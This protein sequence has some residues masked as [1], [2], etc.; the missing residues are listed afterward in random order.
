MIQAPIN[1]PPQAYLDILLPLIDRARGFLEAGEALAPMAFVGALEDRHFVPVLMNNG[2]TEAK[3]NSA[4]VIERTA[5]IIQADFVATIM[6]VWSL[7]Q[8]KIAKMDEIID[9]YGSVANSPYAVD[10]VG[11]TLETRHGVWVAQIPI[12]RKG[13]S[14]KK[15]TIGAPEF[16]WYD[17]TAGRFSGLLPVKEEGGGVLH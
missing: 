2:S 5:R 12:K 15:R 14:K 4:T 7:R 6:E 8:D 1:N 3:D 17:E 16:R 10:T 11:V 13:V 9:R